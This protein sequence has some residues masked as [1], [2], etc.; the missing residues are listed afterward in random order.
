MLRKVFVASLTANIASVT[1]KYIPSMILSTEKELE[2]AKNI[3]FVNEKIQDIEMKTKDLNKDAKL[4]KYWEN[5]GTEKL[6]Q[7]KSTNTVET[8]K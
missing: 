6:T 2:D 4:S 8:N 7:L 3:V 5:S 1:G